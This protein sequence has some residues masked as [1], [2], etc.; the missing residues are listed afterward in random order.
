MTSTE[1]RE[2]NLVHMDVLL[3]SQLLHVR[4]IENAVALDACDDE[5]LAT[6]FKEWNEHPSFAVYNRSPPPMNKK[7]LRDTYPKLLAKY[8]AILTT[9]LANAAY[10]IRLKELDERIIECRAE[11]E[12]VSKEEP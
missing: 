9:T 11:F 1:S 3:L 6:L 12:R 10:H 4:N 7:I 2:S 8:L 5:T